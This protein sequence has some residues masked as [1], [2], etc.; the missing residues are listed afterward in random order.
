MSVTENCNDPI[1]LTWR[2]MHNE[3]PYPIRTSTKLQPTLALLWSSSQFLWRWKTSYFLIPSYAF[4]QNNIKDKR[5]WTVFYYNR[6]VG[7]R[8]L[9]TASLSMLTSCFQEYRSWI[10]SKTFLS[11]P[12]KRHLI[13]YLLWFIFLIFWTR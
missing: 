7:F 13:L 2:T 4:E 10:C 1:L 3:N 6:L 8:L 12:V 11:I 9:Q 5:K